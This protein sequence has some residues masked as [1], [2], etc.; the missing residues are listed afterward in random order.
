MSIKNVANK[1]ITKVKKHSPEILMAVGVCGIVTSTV[2]ACKATT[3]VGNIIEDHKDKVDKVH[4]AVERINDGEVVKCEDGTEYTKEDAT[5]DTAIIY[6][7]TAIKLI[8]LY[9]PSVIIGTA[10][11]G[12]MISSNNILRKRN[13]AIVAAYTAID[14]SFKDYRKRVTDKFG[15]EIDREMLYGITKEKTEEK[16]VDENGKKKTIKNEIDVIDPENLH[17]AY[18]RIFDELSP[19]YEKS[20]E[21]NCSF[22]VAQQ[23]YWNNILQ[24]R[25]HVF[26]NEVYDSLGLR[27]SEAGQMVGWIWDPENKYGEDR[28][29]YIDFGIH[30]VNRKG[31]SE[32]VN[33]YERAILL[34]FNVDGYILDKI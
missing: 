18:A 25:G 33:G 1:A 30:N 31:C 9:G 10:S 3:K 15:E 23:N 6:T 12:A 13:A 14:K 26:L 29:N 22:L 21:Y 8:K 32:F 11:I 34:D 24:A 7:Q 4:H 2:M 27:R 16:T 5:K 17:S 28:D 20:A 19:C